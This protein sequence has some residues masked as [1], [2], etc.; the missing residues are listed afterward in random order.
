VVPGLARGDGDPGA[1]ARVGLGRDT[2]GADENDRAGIAVVADHE[3]GPAGD[4]QRGRPG[5][6]GP[7]YGVEQGRLVLGHDD[8]ARRTADAQRREVGEGRS[9]AASLDRTEVPAYA[10]KVAFVAT[11]R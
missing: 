5:R 3:V 6:V 4:E 1:A 11:S 10:M 2:A 8:L 9:H 7:A